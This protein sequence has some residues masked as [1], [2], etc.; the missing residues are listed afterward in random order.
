MDFGAA[1]ARA[2]RATVDH[3]G[4]EITYSPGTGSPVT[5]SGH[6]D[7]L[8][9]REDA[10][11]AGVATTGPAVFLLLEDLPSDPATDAGVTVTVAATLYRPAGV[12]KDGKG[13]VVIRLHE[14]T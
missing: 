13:G 9:R 14:A 12:E 4:D 7:A 2:D 5:V 1:L 11:Q 6:F 10:S 8:Y 3:L